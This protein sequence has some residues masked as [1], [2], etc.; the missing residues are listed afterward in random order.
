MVKKTIKTSMHLVDHRLW[1][2]SDIE[3]GVEFG[4]RSGARVGSLLWIKF[5][6]NSSGKTKNCIRENMADL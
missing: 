3:S 5:G 6:K 4:V 1:V 2:L